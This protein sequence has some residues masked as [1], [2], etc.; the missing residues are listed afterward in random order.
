MCS[1]FG[2]V[3]QA[4]GVKSFLTLVIHHTANTWRAIPDR[5]SVRLKNRIWTSDFYNKNTA[6]V[7]DLSESIGNARSD[8]L[9]N[10]GWNQEVDGCVQKSR[11]RA[12]NGGAEG[13]G[14]DGQG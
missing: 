3:F 4:S 7:S 14:V 6:A 9:L 1:T 11:G 13:V 8:A 12:E 2:G 10:V 5:L